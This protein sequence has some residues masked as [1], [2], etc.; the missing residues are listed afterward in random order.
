[1]ERNPSTV[2]GFEKKIVINI[3]PLQDFTSGEARIVYDSLHKYFDDLVIS[4]PL[5]IPTSAY[6]VER[7]RYRADTLIAYLRDTK[8]ADTISM[9]L[10]H[11]D[12]STSKGD[13][14]DWG[15]MGLGY[16]PGRA[17]VVSTFRLK[18]SNKN[19]QLIKVVLH[20]L[21]HTLGLDHC[22]D[23]SCLMRDAEGGNPLDQEKDFCARCK[24]HLAGK[25]MKVI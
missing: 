6:V 16:R 22:A 19:E 23:K 13:I 21:G 4:E 3:Q 15:V 12:I 11:Y 7:K 25:G 17:C 10:T 1:M 9:G 20:E 24:K 8:N 2:F 14:K 5:A 18:K